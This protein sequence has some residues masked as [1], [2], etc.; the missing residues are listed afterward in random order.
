LSGGDKHALFAA[1]VLT[2]AGAAHDG[3]LAAAGLISENNILA[4]LD[5]W[6]AQACVR[7]QND[8]REMAS[9]QYL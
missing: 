5:F 4:I 2:M 3:A 9:H 8:L 6:I 7:P 1:S